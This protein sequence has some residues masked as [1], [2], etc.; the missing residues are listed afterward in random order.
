MA[1]MPGSSQQKE[2]IVGVGPEKK[3]KT[4]Q[5]V[6]RCVLHQAQQAQR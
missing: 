2:G 3:Q 6:K 1:Q 5:H 4:T